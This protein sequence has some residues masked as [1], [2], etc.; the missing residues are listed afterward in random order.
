ML[1]LSLK[2][3]IISLSSTN[4]MCFVISSSRPGSPSTVASLTTSVRS[5]REVNLIAYGSKSS[6]NRSP[7]AGQNW[8]GMWLRPR[9]AQ[10]RLIVTSLGLSSWLLCAGEG[11]AEGAE[12]ASP[13]FSIP[14][15]TAA[16]DDARF[17]H[18]HKSSGERLRIHTY[19]ILGIR[20]GLSAVVLI[21]TTL[22]A[23]LKS[24]RTF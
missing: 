1:T 15:G 6:P 21:C 23:V 4:G 22:S 24:K 14:L 3:S 16:F 13:L 7:C 10:D 8:R 9:F 20:W 11:G 17:D 18:V 5:Q 19:V 2:C 12:Q